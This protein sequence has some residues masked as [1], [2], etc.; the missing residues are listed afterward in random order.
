ME[1]A[2]ETV[3]EEAPVPAEIPEKAPERDPAVAESTPVVAAAEP[4]LAATPQWCAAR[5]SGRACCPYTHRSAEE[6][7]HEEWELPTSY[8]ALPVPA[9]TAVEPV[10]P[11]PEP[12][13]HPQ[14]LHVATQPMAEFSAPPHGREFII[15]DTAATDVGGMD[16]LGDLA[17]DLASSLDGLAARQTLLRLACRR[18]DGRRTASAAGPP[19]GAAQLS[20]LLAEMEEPGRRRSRRQGRSRDPLQ[21]GCGFPGDGT[22]GRI[23]W[24]VSK[25]CEG[26]GEGKVSL[27]TSSRR[28]VC[29]RF[30]LWKRRCPRLPSSGTCVRWKRPASTR[31]R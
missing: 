22:V 14:I 7:A 19:Q 20:G 25:S 23:H 12:C 30:V 8:A 27:R 15:E 16:M 1:P 21:S 29:W 9:P 2:T 31:R 13:R 6:P 10:A 26:C 3:R 17:G 24:R 4:E 11:T 5:A 18:T 28:A